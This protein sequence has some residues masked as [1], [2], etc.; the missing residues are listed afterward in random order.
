M[1][2]K[3]SR[4]P[5]LAGDGRHQSEKSNFSCLFRE[6]HTNFVDDQRVSQGIFS[7]KYLPAGDSGNGSLDVSNLFSLGGSPSGSVFPGGGTGC[8]PLG[9]QLFPNSAAL[10]PEGNLWVG[11]N[12]ASSIVK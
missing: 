2:I 9:P 11:F 6:E 10:D 3:K 8:P 7:I 12:K 4:K 5:V 1:L